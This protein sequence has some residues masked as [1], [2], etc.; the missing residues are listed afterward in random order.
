MKKPI[1]IV[2]G[3]DHSMRKP[4]RIILSTI[5]SGPFNEEAN[6]D[7]FINYNVWTIQ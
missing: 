5:M 4:I 3:L 2:L 7:Y 1:R 6:K